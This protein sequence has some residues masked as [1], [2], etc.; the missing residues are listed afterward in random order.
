[1]GDHMS[2]RQTHDTSKKHCSHP[3]VSAVRG[4]EGDE[5]ACA[6]CNEVVYTTAQWTAFREGRGPK[7]HGR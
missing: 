5:G 3:Q 1:M 7:L 2:N 4:A 6:D